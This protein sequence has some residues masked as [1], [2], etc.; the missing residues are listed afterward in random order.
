M[1][2]Q[3][4]QRPSGVLPPRVRSSLRRFE[5]MAVVVGFGLL[6]LT[7]EVILNDGFDNDA[8]SWW[9]PIHGVLYMLYLVATADLALKVRWP[10]R[11][12]VVVMLAGVVPFFSFFMERKVAREVA[13]SGA[14]ASADTLSG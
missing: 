4:A 8:L 5:I 3:Q 6:L 7:L 12:M 11:R 9:S 1:S 13:G 14:G 10:L 2:S